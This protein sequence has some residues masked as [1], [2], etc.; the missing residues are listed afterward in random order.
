MKLR[1]LGL[2]AFLALSTIVVGSGCMIKPGTPTLQ[3][4][5]AFDLQC[6]EAQIQLTELSGCGGIKMA[7]THC[8]MGASGCGRQATYID[9]NGN[10]VMNSSASNQGTQAH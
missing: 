2:V 6:P 1:N 8:T 5:A 3:P 7:G 10:W 9:I 4:R